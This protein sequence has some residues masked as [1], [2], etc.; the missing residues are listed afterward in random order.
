MVVGCSYDWWWVPVGNDLGITLMELFSP[1]SSVGS[2]KMKDGKEYSSPRQNENSPTF[3]E[4]YILVVGLNRDTPTP[5]KGEIQIGPFLGYRKGL[6]MNFEPHMEFV[7][8]VSLSFVY[9]NS[10]PVTIH[11]EFEPHMEFG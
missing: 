4:Y 5:K 10:T 6:G 8:G 3:M 2:Q 9:L 1:N 11:V 7:S